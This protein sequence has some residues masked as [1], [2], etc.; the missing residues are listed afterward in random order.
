MSIKRSIRNFHIFSIVALSA[1]AGADD[2]PPTPGQSQAALGATNPPPQNPIPTLGL[3]PLAAIEEVRTHDQEPWVRCR[4]TTRE[5]AA[6]ELGPVIAHG[7]IEAPGYQ[8]G[9]LTPAQARFLRRASLRRLPLSRGFVY[10]DTSLPS[11]TLGDSQLKKLVEG[12]IRVAG[13]EPPGDLEIQNAYDTPPRTGAPGPQTQWVLGFSHDRVPIQG[14]RCRLSAMREGEAFGALA[15]WLPAGPASEYEPFTMPERRV[16]Q[17]AL[18]AAGMRG[19]RVLSKRHYEL[20]AVGREGVRAVARTQVVLFNGER[21]M[22]VNLDGAG[23]VLERFETGRHF[24]WKGLPLDFREGL[25][26]QDTDYEVGIGQTDFIDS[27]DKVEGENCTDPLEDEGPIQG[28]Y[29]HGFV[30]CQN[31]ALASA[32][33]LQPDLQLTHPRPDNHFN[34]APNAPP[35]TGFLPDPLPPQLVDTLPFGGFDVPARP[36]AS[37]G[38]LFNAWTGAGDPA[39]KGISAAGYAELQ[40]F[41]SVGR[42]HKI[43]Y[44]NL[45]HL[46]FEA[47][48]GASN[49]EYLKEQAFGPKY[50]FELRVHR[51]GGIL[52]TAA[53]LSFMDV[54]SM[55]A[56]PDI[57]PPSSDRLFEVVADGSILSHEYHHHIQAEVEFEY[58]QAFADPTLPGVPAV[59]EGMADLYGAVA[60]GRNKVGQLA[61]LADTSDPCANPNAYPTINVNQG[62]A[63]LLRPLCNDVSYSTNPPPVQHIAGMALSGALHPYVRRLLDSGLGEAAALADVYEGEFVY[64]STLSKSSSPAGTPAGDMRRVL[65]GISAGLAYKNPLSPFNNPGQEP[66]IVLAPSRRRNALRASFGAKRMTL[67]PANSTVCTSSCSTTQVASLMLRLLSMVGPAR[68]EAQ[69]EAISPTFEIFTPTGNAYETVDGTPVVHL[70]FSTSSSY[71]SPET[72]DVLVP[73]PVNKEVNG[74]FRYQLPA[75]TWAQLRDAA[76]ATA[77]D[78]L[79]YRVKR[80]DASGSTPWYSAQAGATYATFLQFGPGVGDNGCSCR[81]PGTTSPGSSQGL[82]LL[83]LLGLSVLRRRRG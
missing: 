23:Q 13:F 54:G 5:V 71:A 57:V 14:A 37:T 55:S 70:E 9:L 24:T 38:P 83:A 16:Q 62:S 65:E 1:C 45:G 40:L 74:F 81:V 32:F 33:P 53:G 80:L 78:R 15:C 52:S 30:V 59:A 28:A 31:E 69:Q 35:P 34:N 44:K 76:Q 29:Q 61:K 82:S 49:P 75:S 41:H 8:R 72:V 67:D 43:L 20:E 19:A 21:E 73:P 25:R 42:R 77:D 51:G 79:Y 50:R 22:A 10:E 63:P 46:G 27:A 17:Q 36:S 2:E 7:F 47:L 12:A 60:V 56:H 11:T 66:D 64:W 3:D 58:N 18:Q 4:T 6:D 39:K 48:N 68:V 26:E